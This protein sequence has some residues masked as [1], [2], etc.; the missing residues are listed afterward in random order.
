MVDMIF[1]DL[2]RRSHGGKSGLAARS[3]DQKQSVSG[4]G[5]TTFSTRLTD[6]QK[7][8][9]EKAA[10]IKGW[11]PSNLFRIAAIEKAVHILNASSHTNFNFRL[12]AQET[13]MQLCSQRHAYGRRT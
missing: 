10:E 9:I 6:K 4:A 8:W 13:A 11:T 2:N 12:F 3:S 5:S 7:E 1:N